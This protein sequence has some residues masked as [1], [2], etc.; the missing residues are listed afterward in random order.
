[1]SRQ[2]A[3]SLLYIWCKKEPFEKVKFLLG[4]VV[5][6]A[7]LP[8]AI[9][10]YSVLTGESVYAELIGIAA[11]HAFIFI[12]EVLPNNPSYRLDLFKTPKFV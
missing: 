1:M 3:F 8:W 6:S 11:G 9:I 12:K 5:K 4:F 7:Y 2:F 10:I